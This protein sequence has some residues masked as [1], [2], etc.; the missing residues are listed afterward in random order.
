MRIPL[1]DLGNVMLKIDFDR[2]A[3][4]IME[5][6]EIRDI[7]EIRKFPRS[8]LWAEYEFG[9]IEKKD[10]VRRARALF[11]AEFSDA[12]FEDKFCDIFSGTVPGMEKLLDD[13]LAAGPVYVLSN[14]NELHQKRYTELFPFLSKV[15]KIYASHEIHKRKPYPG[16]YRDIVKEMGVAPGN[17][18]FFDDLPE[19][20]NGARRAGLFA[21]VFESAEKAEALWRELTSS[22]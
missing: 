1:L 21:H 15:T 12:E 7:E 5:R 2:F 6:S 16:T 9:N 18:I 17:V 3:A 19:N 4:W 13:F 22:A 10:F 11:R 14:T 20:V 8:S